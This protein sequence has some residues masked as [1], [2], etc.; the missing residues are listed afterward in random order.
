MLAWRVNPTTP[1]FRELWQILIPKRDSESKMQQC[2]RETD[3]AHDARVA[4]D[5]TTPYFRKLWQILTVRHSENDISSA[6][7]R[8][9][10]L[11]MLAWRVN[12]TTPYFRE[13][14][15]IL[16]PKRDSESEMVQ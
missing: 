9:M 15:Q 10:M 5:P 1:Y 8:R 2:N 4:G 11:I 6:T 12:P 13:L 16:I 3:D 7:A 14:W